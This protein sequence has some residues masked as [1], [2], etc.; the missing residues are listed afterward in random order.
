MIVSHF[1]FGQ[2]FFTAREQFLNLWNEIQTFADLV[3]STP[4]EQAEWELLEKQ[5]R[6][7][8]T[9]VVIGAVNTGKSMFLNAL[10]GDD[11]CPVSPLPETTYVTHYGYGE[12]DSEVIVGE[13]VC[14]RGKRL[15]VLRNLEVVDTPGTG[16]GLNAHEGVLAPYMESA[17]F[18]FVVFSAQNPWEASTWN[19]V[20]QFSADMLS[21]TLLIVQQR[22]QCVDTDIE[23]ILDHMGDLVKK[24]IHVMLPIFVVS[25]N[26]LMA[27]RKTHP[28]DVRRYRASGFAELDALIS[29][30]INESEVRQ[31]E[32]RLAVDRANLELS[33]LEEHLNGYVRE[34][35]EHGYFLEQLDGEIG[36]MRENFSA[37][38]NE[39]FAGV[40]EGLEREALQVS[41]ILHKR[42]SPLRS[43][44]RLFGVDGVG[45]E[46]E[47]ALIEHLQSALGKAAEKDGDEILEACHAHWRD[48]GQRAPEYLGIDPRSLADAGPT[49]ATARTYFVEHLEY[50]SRQGV[51]NLKVRKRLEKDLRK[52][53]MSL[54]SFMVTTLSLSIAASGSG[55]L[56]IPWVPFVFLLLAFVFLLGGVFVAWMTRAAVEK[57]FKFRLVNV[58][59]AFSVALRA[60]YEEAL[61]WFF[62]DYAQLLDVLHM[63]IARERLDLEP[64]MN[65]Q[66]E[67]FLSLKAFEQSR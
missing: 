38:L 62:V 17:D 37:R 31:K 32:L 66:R 56:G 36:V 53:T 4:S 19:R 49:L 40:A 28:M 24:R 42:L 59:G 60:D 33:H 16:E 27:A 7:P 34:V 2:R 55:I 44:V 39:H 3:V 61:S 30:R 35:D 51:G 57:E 50:A 6:R 10:V 25:A 45:I 15:D 9:A 14:L 46:M 47:N 52:R 11:L 43:L 18:I 54:K 29:C 12:E 65:R 26:E 21:R 64:M 1:P 41:A 48:I 58:C 5:L 22:D 8:F 23:V 20:S 13:G 63:Y 67:L